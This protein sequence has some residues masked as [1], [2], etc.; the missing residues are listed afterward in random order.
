[1]VDAGSI[2]GMNLEK[3]TDD[4][5][6]QINEQIRNGN[7]YDLLNNKFSQSSSNLKNNDN[8]IKDYFPSS[9]KTFLNTKR[10]SQFL[11]KNTKCP[12]VDSRHYAKNMCSNCYHSRGRIKKS[13]RCSHTDRPHYALGVCQNC[14]QSRYSKV[15]IFFI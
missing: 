4:S 5:I 10:S 1:V 8:F 11:K 13:W 7:L 3:K 15:H 6:Y 2:F 12:H 9:N 14:Y